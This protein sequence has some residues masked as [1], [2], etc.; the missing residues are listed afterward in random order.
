MAKRH[1]QTGRS[2]GRALRGESAPIGG[3]F[4]ARRLE[5]LESPAMRVLSL[6]ARRVLD[7]IEIELC[8]H[9]GKDNGR[10]P[11]TFADFEHFGIDRHAIGPALREAEAL[12]FIEIT[13]RG[14]AGNA[15]FRSP[16]YFRLTYR[17]MKRAE[18]TDEWQRHESTEDAAAAAKAARA[19]KSGRPAKQNSSGGKH[20]FSVGETRTETR[21][22]P[23]GETP[24]TG[25]PEKP[26][27]LSTSRG[28]GEG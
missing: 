15:E 26:P 23:V 19:A 6:S 16:N 20:Q 21:T 27:L 11:V 18:P 14:R 12:G 8:H 5:M 9:A 10:L 17:H 24:T 28:G 7:R 25:K 1:D 2:T 22:A 4:A 3:S 13:E